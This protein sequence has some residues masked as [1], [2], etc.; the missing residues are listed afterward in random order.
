VTAYLYQV[1]KVDVLAWN[2][3]KL[4]T[5][6]PLPNAAADAAGGLIISDLG[7]FDVDAIT[8][9]LNTISAIN[10]RIPAALVGG[11]M[12]SNVSAVENATEADTG[13]GW[14]A[15]FKR[16]LSI[17]DGNSDVE[18]VGANHVVTFKDRAGNPE[19]VHTVVTATGA[20]TRS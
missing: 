20:R 8:P 3:V 5:T 6:N 17:K 19:T 14:L 15:W 11:R 7:G 4:A 12:D 10:L 16:M 9:A 2:S 1:D 18:V 13:V